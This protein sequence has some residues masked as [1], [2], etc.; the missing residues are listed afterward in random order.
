MVWTA[1][2]AQ[3]ALASSLCLA[4]TATLAGCDTQAKP[5]PSSTPTATAT[6]T[7]TPT[8]STSPSP[9]LDAADILSRAVVENAAL[10]SVFTMPVS[11]TGNRTIEAE[12]AEGHQTEDNAYTLTVV[13]APFRVEKDETRTLDD[14]ATRHHL[15]AEVSTNPLNGDGYL[16]Y[17][18]EGEG[19]WVKNLA[20]HFDL[21]TE[22]AGTYAATHVAELLEITARQPENIQ[23][24]ASKSTVTLTATPEG[25]VRH[26]LVI[27][28]FGAPT[29]TYGEAFEE[30]TAT[31]VV[32]LDASTYRVVSFSLSAAGVSQNGADS[33]ELAL[34]EECSYDFEPDS[35]S[36]VIPDEARAMA[37]G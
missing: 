37:F 11:L 10:A 28:A 9:S 16:V 29:A 31:L 4:A 13:D 30:D 26:E 32:T 15:F 34:R 2:L 3:L 36:V 12:Q 14:I 1:R 35:N 23:V 19:E 6:A 20:S 22:A 7:V 5:R 8:Q 21:L 33:T 17:T 18:R 24:E 27:T 25:D